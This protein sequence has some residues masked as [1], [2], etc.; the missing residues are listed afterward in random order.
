MAKMFIAG[1]LVGAGSGKTYEV[2][3]PATG[4]VMVDSGA[5]AATRVM[6][7]RPS[8]PLKRHFQP[9]PTPPGKLAPN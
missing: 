7:E 3:N 2:F 1:E 9:G 8:M 4:E 6:H 5:E